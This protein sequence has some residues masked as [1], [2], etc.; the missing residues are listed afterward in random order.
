MTKSEAKTIEQRAQRALRN[1]EGVGMPWA[2]MP[3]ALQQQIL[4]ALQEARNEV[5]AI[6]E[7]ATA[8]LYPNK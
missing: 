3:G 2:Q 8:E 7:M 1:I 4:Q 5:N 6:L